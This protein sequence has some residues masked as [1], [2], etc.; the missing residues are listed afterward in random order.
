[1]Q[2]V[3]A[4]NRLIVKANDDVALAQA[5]FSCGT[6]VFERDDENPAFNREVVVANDA[7]RCGSAASF[8]SNSISVFITQNHYGSG[9]VIPERCK[10]F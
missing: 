4:G 2:I 7:A 10:K 5:T 3:N 8:I 1:V 9:T 6:L